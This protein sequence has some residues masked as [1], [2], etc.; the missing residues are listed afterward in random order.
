M[1]RS[2]CMY[3][4]LIICQLTLLTAPL[5]IEHFFVASPTAATIA[6][7]DAMT[8]NAKPLNS[9]AA[10]H[11]S[12][13]GR[14][15]LRKKPSR[16]HL[17]NMG[18]SFDLLEGLPEIETPP[19]T[20]TNE[21]GP[22][23]SDSNSTTEQPPSSVGE[24]EGKII[25]GELS[26][27]TDINK[28]E[29]VIIPEVHH[30]TP[31]PQPKPRP[32]AR[33]RHMPSLD[34]KK[35]PPPQ[36][37]P[38][39]REPT[40]EGGGVHSREGSPLPTHKPLVPPPAPVSAQKPLVPP[41]TAHKPLDSSHATS[42]SANNSP[43]LKKKEPILPSPKHLPKSP[44][45]PPNVELK[46][47]EDSGDII[48]P[49]A[50]PRHLIEQPP[51]EIEE[52]SIPAKTAGS[53][54]PPV[55]IRAISAPGSPAKARL[56]P[57]VSRKPKSGEDL[58]HNHDGQLSPKRSMSFDDE[59]EASPRHRKKMPAG[60]VNIMGFLPVTTKLKHLEI[61]GGGR[62]RS[63]TVSTTEPGARERDTLKRQIEKHEAS[64]ISHTKPVEEETTPPVQDEDP[65][66][67]ETKK[68]PPKRP[69]LPTA[70][71]PANNV[72]Q[73]D[74]PSSDDWDSDASPMLATKMEHQNEAGL[75]YSS[76][77]SWT[78]EGVGLW[79][80]RIGLGRYQSVFV[81]RGVAGGDLFDIDGH[82]LKVGI[83]LL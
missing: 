20:E 61:G 36:A 22:P 51:Q 69:P 40:I 34:D 6:E 29:T 37:A 77:L 75:D 27:S 64:P 13:V 43:L 41:P 31:P 33:V 83:M 76:M 55:I 26:T 9:S 35:P 70:K 73:V 47:T 74:G 28:T 39:H 53:D 8:L 49:T 15:L 62:E 5:I 50:H 3:V 52:E 2:Q 16:Q 71:K 32:R 12:Q 44:K 48:H 1:L 65:V 38:R 4:L 68:L 24:N 25:L 45:M 56:P 11:K 19:T 7:F 17:K 82:S 79:M 80:D 60:A 42:Q 18:S 66:V 58:Q 59:L 78:P 23:H 10:I 21:Q 63:C 30:E 67:M 57:P 46:L 81:E 54:S 72:E 14:K